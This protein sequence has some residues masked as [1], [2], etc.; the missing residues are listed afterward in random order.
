MISPVRLSRTRFYN[1]SALSCRHRLHLRFSS[2]SVSSPKPPLPPPPPTNQPRLLPKSLRPYAE[3]FRDR[4]VSHVTSFLILHELTAVLP[5]A[6]LVL[7]FHQTQWSPPGLPGEWIDAG[8]KK[9]GRYVRLFFLFFS[10]LSFLF[11]SFFSFCRR[12]DW[13]GVDVGIGGEERLGKV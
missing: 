3:R 13:K 11:L 1:L 5:L 2:N 10:F 9:F 12:T 8:M 4:P 6:G 7:L